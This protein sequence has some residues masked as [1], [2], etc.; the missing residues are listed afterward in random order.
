MNLP[1]VGAGACRGLFTTNAFEF[2]LIFL[3]VHE[4]STSPAALGPARFADHFGLELRAFAH[5]PLARIVAHGFVD[6]RDFSSSLWPC[7]FHGPRPDPRLVQAVVRAHAWSRQL[8]DG[9]YNSIE[10]AIA[11]GM[12]VKVV[13]KAIRLAFLAPDIVAAILAGDNLPTARLN[14]SQSELPLSWAVQRQPSK[15]I[16]EEAAGRASSINQDSL[17]RPWFR[18]PLLYPAEL[19][20]PLIFSSS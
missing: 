1:S 7:H 6:G 5:G 16:Y 20:D 13:R 11:H 2:P 8:S 3:N 17:L 4:L 9:T 10:L 12:H 19:R 15:S 14:A 18:K